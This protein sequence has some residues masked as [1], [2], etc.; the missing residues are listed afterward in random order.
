[1]SDKFSPRSPRDLIDLVRS[2]PLAWI[3]SG[4]AGSLQTT[5]LPVQLESDAAGQPLR[6]LGHFGRSN[7]HWRQLMDSP[8]ATILLLGPQGYI[9]PSWFADRT[10]APTWNYASASFDVEVDICD[11]PQDA[12][13]LLRGLTDDL[14]QDRPAAW[15][16]EDMGARYDKLAQGVVGFRAR[17]L[18]VSS[19]FK[20]GQDERDDV[21][22][23]ILRGLELTG[24]DDLAGW[25]RRFGDQR[26]PVAAVPPPS[27]L[28]PDIMRF[29]DDV[30]ATGRR[31][32]AGRVLD[33]PARRAIAEQSRL[34]WQAGG[35]QMASVTEKVADTEAGPVHLRFYDPAPGAAKPALVYMHGGG[36]ALFSL[37]T[38]DRL[39]REFAARSGMTVIG[40]DY[41]LAPEARY[42]IALNQVVATVRWLRTHGAE[43]GIDPERLALGGDSAG[44]SL[45]FGAALK[46]RDAG[47]PDAVKAILGIYGGFS[48]D[49]SPAARQRY[50]TPDD[51]L[52]SDE[53]DEFWDTYIG[54]VA[55]R[56]DPYLATLLADLRGMPPVFLLVAE[57]DVLAEQNMLMAGRLLEAEV[58]VK[59]KVYPGAP[60]S[61]IEAMEVSKVAS[62]AI[63]DGAA[64]LREMLSTSSN[65]PSKDAA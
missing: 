55:D 29:I 5:V 53:V 20:L 28:D 65:P 61:F 38:H 64:W 42:P 32:S 31:L 24:A 11:T 56:R 52:T 30:R 37:D 59:V 62:D 35:P 15:R 33:W 60:H 2:Q 50:G 4:A 21:F 3:V 48:P 54:S 57:C 45:S 36:W 23:D 18:K 8:R 14:E 41:A 22:A 26:A 12:A 63:D 19:R 44:G 16:I 46:L 43:L 39:M 7:A 49:P 1:M 9:S 25:M 40:V 10:Q 34:P 51:M 13:A 58:P 6:I 47:E 27:P 17:I